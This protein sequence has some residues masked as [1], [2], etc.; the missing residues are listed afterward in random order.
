[1]ITP[2]LK[3]AVTVSCLTPDCGRL[4]IRLHLAGMAPLNLDLSVRTLGL[5]AKAD[6]LR[7]ARGA[8][9]TPSQF[10]AITVRSA[11]LKIPGG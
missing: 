7:K 8:L 4:P 5:P 3:G 6:S 10:G 1:M 2:A 9:A 11:K